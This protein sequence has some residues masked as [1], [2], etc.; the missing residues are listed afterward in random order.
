MKITI[1]THPN[2]KIEYLESLI[3]KIEKDSL[4]NLQII[5]SWKKVKHI[6]NI[7]GVKIYAISDPFETIEN[8]MINY[9]QKA[10]DRSLRW[11]VIK[12]VMGYDLNEYSPIEAAALSYLLWLEIAKQ[13][14][15]DCIFKIED[16]SDLFKFLIDK[17]VLDN[18]NFNFKYT[19]FPNF[20]IRNFSL[21]KDIS[22]A[23]LNLIGKYCNVYQ[24]ENYLK[25]LR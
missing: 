20:K 4:V 22:Y 2:Q 13:S 11:N 21:Y 15:L 8:C 6:N 19:K 7:D 18:R 14:D 9:D 17:G 3:S 25:G 23:T 5:Y 24:Y 12:K 1:F 16:P 10:T